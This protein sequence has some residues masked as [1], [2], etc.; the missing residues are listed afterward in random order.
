MN[1]TL[2]RSLSLLL[3]IVMILGMT[4][5]ASAASVT[6]QFFDSTLSIQYN[7]TYF[8][9]S[10]DGTSLTPIKTV[11]AAGAKV[12]FK[13]ISTEKRTL[14]FE[15]SVSAGTFEIMYDS[16]SAYTSP[17]PDSIPLEAGESIVVRIKSGQVTITNINFL[18][19]EEQVS[20]TFVPGE[21]GSFTVDG[22][23]ITE[24]TILQESNLHN[25]VLSATPDEG[26]EFISWYDQTNQRSLSNDSSTE[27][28]F[29][30]D[31]TVTALFMK[32]SSAEDGA[33]CVNTSYFES[34][35]DARVY[36]AG[37]GADTVV[38]VQ[39]YT[40]T[41][42]LTIPEGI[43]LLI[44]YNA[45]HTCFTNDVS[46]TADPRV[47][48]SKYQ[49]PS[50]Y[51]TLTL[52]GGVTLTV[53]GKLSVS[54]QH[55]ASAGSSN[56]FGPT[57]PCGYV[58]LESG[59]EI[60]V[61]GGMYAYGYVYGPG[62]VTVNS[63]A[64]VYE[65]MQIAG[66]RGGTATLT[67]AGDSR[68]VFPLSQ[69]YIQNVESAMILMAGAKEYAVTSLMPG[70]GTSVTAAVPFIHPTD[71][72]FRMSDG[73]LTKSYLGSS[74]RLELDVDGN[75][76]INSLVIDIPG[77]T[78][79]NSANFVLP[80]TNNISI[81]VNGGSVALGQ[82]IAFLP[83]TRVNVA[84]GATVDVEDGHKVYVYDRDEWMSH[85][86]SHP[87][88]YFNPILYSPGK[89]YTRTTDDLV[90]ARMDVNG[91][92]IING[93]A[94]TTEH[95]AEI[96][97]TG[98]SGYVVFNQAA[99]TETET[100]QY[101][102]SQLLLKYISIPIESIAL[103]NGPAASIDFTE[104][105]GTQANTT[106][107]WSEPEDM[108]VQGV[109]VSF[110]ANGG[111]G[112][113]DPQFIPG[114]DV[115]DTLTPL[116]PNT[117][118]KDGFKFAGWSFDGEE[119]IYEDQA[120]FE[121]SEEGWYNTT[122]YATWEAT[123]QFDVTWI[124][125][126]GNQLAVTKVNEGEHP[127]YKGDEPTKT[128]TVE[129]DFTFAG[130]TSDGGTT[131]Y[132]PNDELPVVT[133]KI[134]YTA[135]FTEAPRQ[136]RVAYNANGGAG[137][138]APEFCAY[139]SEKTLTANAFTRS[140]YSFAG[141]NTAAD[142][143]G[144]AYAD[145]ATVTISG[146]L[147]L[148]A[149]WELNKYTIT[150]KNY[151]GTV[152]QEV[153]VNNGEVPV[154]TGNTPVREADTYHTYRFVGWKTSGSNTIYETLPA[155]TA[156]TVYTAT[157]SADIRQYRVTFDPQG[158]F[159]QG[160]QYSYLNDTPYSF[161]VDAGDQPRVIFEVQ[162][163]GYRLV[164]W[165]TKADGTGESKKYGDP[166]EVLSD[167][168]FYAI[169]E[170]EHYTI[171]F[172]PGFTAEG[173][174]GEVLTMASI[175][176]DF[177]DP[178]TLPDCEFVHPGFTFNGWKD[179]V[180]NMSYADHASGTFKENI[181]LTAQWK[182]TE[183]KVIFNVNG[184]SDVDLAEF[185]LDYGSVITLPETTREG[186][187]MQWEVVSGKDVGE[188]YDAGDEYPVTQDT[189][190]KAK[191]TPIEYTITFND[192]NGDELYSGTVP[193]G[194]T[195]EY[196]Y[197]T[198][199]RSG[200][201]QYS[202][203]F[204]EWTPAIVP[205]T[206]DATYTAV[207]TATVNKY[208]IEFVNW[209]GDELQSSEVEYGETPVY[210]G[211]TPTKAADAQYTYTFAGWDPAIE[212]VTCA[213]TYRAQFT[214]TVNRYTIKF[215]NWDG[216]V[217]QSDEVEY[218]QTPAYNG[219]TP[220]KAATAQYTYTFAG[221][222]PEIASVTGEATYTATYT[223]TVN[224][225][226]ITFVNWNGD[227]LQSGKVA[228]GETPAYEG[229]EPTKAATAQY[230]YTFKGWTPEIVPVTEDATYTAVFT[231]T[232][233]KYTITWTM[234]DD[235][236]IDTTEV[237]FGSVPTHADAVKANDELY[238]YSF[239]GWSPNP[240]AVNGPATYK[241]TFTATAIPHTVTFNKGDE[242]A[243]GT[244]APLTI[245]GVEET[246]LTANAFTLTGYHFTG[247]IDEEGTTYA[248]QAK[249]KATKD[250]NLTAQW[251]I[252]TYTITWQNDD[253][254]VIDTTTVEHGEIPTHADANKAETA[255]FTYTFAGWNPTPVA[256]TENA[257]YKAVFT[258]EKRSYTITWKLDEN[259]VI[260][261]TTVEYGAMPTHADATKANTAEWTYTFAGWTPEV[262]AVTG[263]AE[264]TA[265]FD[266]T[267][268]KYTITFKNDNGDVLEAKEWEYGDMPSYD[269]SSLIKPADVQYSYTFAGWTPEIA[270]VTG[271]AEY[272]AT[273]EQTLNKYTV[274]WKN[275]DGGVLL[276]ENLD[277]GTTPKYT[278][279]E[280]GKTG[281]AQYSYVFNGWSD[282]VNN[283]L[284]TD[285]LP[286]VTGDITYT[287]TFE[288]VVNKYTIIF[289]NW[290]DTELQ[291]SEV[292]YGKMPAYTGGTPTRP[293]DEVNTY[294]FAG[295]EPVL[296]Q[297]TGDATY[298]AK[299]TEEK[300]E[301]TITFVNWDGTLLQSID[302]EYGQLPV[303]NGE[304][305]TREG[306]AQYT[307]TF[308]GWTPAINPVMGDATY[309]A[310]FDMTV[311]TYTVTWKNGDTVLDEETYEYGKMPSYKGETP[312]KA[313]DAQYSYTFTGWDPAVDM[314]TG[315][316]TY[317]AKFDAT[318]NTYTV[319]WKD[320]DGTVL[321]TDTNV[322]YGTVPTF[323]GTQPSKE[324]TNTTVYTFAGWDPEVTAVTGD[325]VYTAKY[326]E[327]VRMYT[328][329]YKNGDA[330]LKSYDV[331][332]EAAVPAYDG[333]T[334]VKEGNA[335]F[336]YTFSGWDPAIEEG[337]K[338]TENMTFTAQFTESV[339]RYKVTWKVDGQED[340]VETYEYN[341]LPSY[342]NGAT[343]AKEPTAEFTYTFAGW[344]P[345]VVAVTGDATY[346][347]KFTETKRSYTITWKNDD[348]TTFATTTVAYGDMP[349]EPEGT[350][351]KAAAAN[352][353]GAY[354]FTGW[355]PELAVVDGDQT[356][357]A[358]F[359][360]TGW[361]T[362]ETGKQYFIASELQNTGLT[363]IDG[364][365]YYLD[366]E[367]GYAAQSTVV[368]TE[369]GDPGHAF[370]ADGK[371]MEGCKEQVFKDEKN[372]EIYL[373]KDGIVEVYPGLYQDP[374]TKF[375]YYFG[376]DEGQP[377]NTAIRGTDAWVE[378][379]H[380]DPNN[381][382]DRGM[383]PKWGY[384]F[385]ENGVIEHD[386]VTLNGIVETA[387]G[388]YY[389]YIDG[390]KV[391]YGMF[392]QDGYY[393]YADRTGKLITS[394]TYW[395]SD[396][397]TLWPEGPYSFDE[398]G[399]MIL[400]E[401]KNGIYEEDGSL[402]YYV[403]GVRNYAGLVYLTGST[404]YHAKDGT[405][406]PADEGWYYVKG[407]GE[408]V[409]SRSY[410]ITKTNGSETFPQGAYSFSDRGTMIMPEAPVL[411]NGV[412][413]EKD[414]LYYY[415]DDQLTY[416][417]LIYMDENTP[418]TAADGTVSSM[419]PGYYYV[420]GT[421]E[422]I[423]GR[424]YWITKTNDIEGF[425]EGAYNFDEK[426]KL[427]LPDAP[428]VKN[429][430]Y[431]ENDSLFYYVDGSLNYAGLI[432]LDGNTKYH[433]AD[434]SVRDVKA[435]YYYV[436]GT[437]EMIHGRSYWITKTNDIPGFKQG[438]Y[439]FDDEGCMVQ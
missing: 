361:R 246:E 298:K 147:T 415:V 129:K 137:T 352:E 44:P 172:A 336:S 333:E 101:D 315:D 307:Y 249:V 204:Q 166:Y 54:A 28:S 47:N 22:T 229:A 140:G 269:T 216:T 224:K 436:K 362:D 260:D 100:Y 126:D 402:F 383:L 228:Y 281:D 145:K 400:S 32:S 258:A 42:D 12:T 128:S 70:E 340:L 133:A 51:K 259:T 187:T 65:L 33:F 194:D 342:M 326:T 192:W 320:E 378:N 395:C 180:N 297:V 18:P 414:S 398:F 161:D 159:F 290:D 92:L 175:S 401:S 207:Y 433:A 348:G 53:N 2:K 431:E 355:T 396:N 59:S 214:T 251:A 91:L 117:F 108:W 421:G 349:T 276:G 220:T 430:I 73:V 339:N 9:C 242:N 127:V 316:A 156:D 406:T 403:D 111:E 31:T 225:Y 280:P 346:T 391:H 131:V 271:P 102:Q 205:V 6:S 385:D 64:E 439:T 153:E 208:T 182:V 95:S 243:E 343:P 323:D 8:S 354:T 164:E 123:E 197:G 325:A 93:E 107:G 408:V 213:V 218:G 99:G 329:Q 380:A 311:N 96:I 306:D 122:L 412:Y 386:D 178:Y 77:L 186:Y 13:N 60:T 305:P 114:N 363:E 371:W 230:T 148:Y 419:E 292:E 267:K 69:Y 94:Y 219:E 370:D 206:G 40:L 302:V 416:A 411:K 3:A 426:G 317:T 273:Y 135:V 162:K 198:P 46:T 149:Q 139:G 252:N 125:G 428:Q 34:F 247:W 181:T 373:V 389:Y 377:G 23:A 319:T 338:V 49:T 275:W 438:A 253:G 341:A 169:W 353:T 103:K 264:Y 29:L 134:T 171:S 142:G 335:Q 308:S 226:T 287:A 21:H 344:E 158:G 248:D 312:Q 288:T 364:A 212:E 177:G 176:G 45:A 26:Y 61:N 155:A 284:L 112:T 210:N 82:D 429:G 301:Y 417:G 66:F 240:V 68:R 195:P 157:F 237:E 87:K 55:F 423:H 67:M 300:N 110:N 337:A 424:S 241:A 351:V 115:P 19:D 80:I 437:G 255:E 314:V 38:L 410:W 376:G 196:P 321:E 261:T 384:V 268:N 105:S 244:M 48:N 170:P 118:T 223:E 245:N 168:T 152:L 97:T 7:D 138:M 81:N 24:V 286:A 150:F 235:S 283:Y 232:V 17:V 113:M 393:Y 318:V 25:Y 50:P 173:T 165:N 397:Y 191:W 279:G 144:T 296:T 405:V 37:I 236:L 76:S 250:L 356:Y 390:V 84:Q 74:D 404:K 366:P 190:F 270:M 151:D 136:Y 347:A 295:W 106:F 120:G 293:A 374:E 88:A 304:T 215:E 256:A 263:D 39:D 388:E 188:L 427:V 369:E 407:T 200:N 85:W 422:L 15:Y 289:V 227:E 357:T 322:P 52:A 202:Y 238:S 174:E 367:T 4:V 285:T 231:E 89:A 434:G 330:V 41:E 119:L 5:T 146:D 392:Y 328:V 217:L 121:G 432:Y 79:V 16:S 57:G 257:T 265:T 104:T 1:K 272:T 167:I 331:V 274:T 334:P 310:T 63:G 185:D 193:Y 299:F 86:F 56:N 313:A 368:S 160:D 179:M 379:N 266:A 201:A 294:V 359:S 10:S 233:N 78:T 358:S 36:A 141:W 27:L 35:E 282:G 154:Y 387:P 72:M 254:T 20:V 83:G 30:E 132:G 418:F 189:T 381:P 130:W 98:H 184:G 211:E 43:T 413:A 14:S 75:G 350:P 382:T 239:A 327:T 163:N 291:R 365:K 221:W 360:Y 116:N 209:N 345:A 375:F 372:D 234:D 332:Y 420:K 203:T 277:Y 278:G 303:Y 90:D 143:N 262:V 109:L 394:K 183:C 71:G 425:K 324:Q 62:Q 58:Y 409:H 435:G 199:T 399:R 11:G 222:T 124:D 309:T